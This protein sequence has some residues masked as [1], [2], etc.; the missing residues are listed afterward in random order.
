MIFYCSVPVKPPTRPAVLLAAAA[1]FVPLADVCATAADDEHTIEMTSA[2][3]N[4]TSQIKIFTFEL[5]NF[6]QVWI[7][8][9][10]LC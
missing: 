5:K 1:V 9:F 6:C 7:F 10:N 4:V 8:V 3:E 2:K